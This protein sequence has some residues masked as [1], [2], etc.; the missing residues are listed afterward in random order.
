MNKKIVSLV[1][2]TILIFPLITPNSVGVDKE[3]NSLFERKPLIKVAIIRQYWDP[4][5]VLFTAKLSNLMHKICIRKAQLD[6]KVRFRIYEFWDNWLFGDVQSGMLQL[7]DIDIVIAPGGVG[8]FN[9]PFL[10]RFQLKRFIRSGGGFYGICGDSTFGSMGIKNMRW[11]YNPLISRLL[12]Y[13]SFSPMLKLANVYTDAS[14]FRDMIKYPI[15]FNRLNVLKFLYELPQSRSTIH[16]E[17]CDIP[18]QKPYEGQDMVTMLG[19]APFVDGSI[20]KRLFMNKVYTIATIKTAD[21]PYGNRITGKKAII[22]TEYGRGKVVLSCIHSQL[23]LGGTNDIHDVY[24]R[25]LL[26][27]AGELEG[28]ERLS[29]KLKKLT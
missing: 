27:V 20:L 22:A 5:D 10:Y 6:Y 17:D 24:A 15:F 13:E 25:N 12:G 1:L 7:R 4:L 3:D 26:W 28:S 19:N 11:Q 14:A 18:I 16:F 2:L 8:S 23:T 29:Y 9:T 21:K